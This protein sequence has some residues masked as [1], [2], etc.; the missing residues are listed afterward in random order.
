MDIQRCCIQVCDT[1]DFQWTAGKYRKA[2]IY[3]GFHFRTAGEQDIDLIDTGL[4]LVVVTD[5][6][7]A[8]LQHIVK[9]DHAGRL[10]QGGVLIVGHIQ[11]FQGDHS[12]QRDTA[13]CDL[14]GV[15]LYLAGCRTD[16]QYRIFILQYRNLAGKS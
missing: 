6:E 2:D 14:T 12:A 9:R 5:S 10:R 13:V 11:D 3:L 8:Q 7:I 1:A 4:E 16:L 15:D